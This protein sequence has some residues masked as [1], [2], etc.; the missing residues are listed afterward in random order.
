MKWHR[1]YEKCATCGLTETPHKARGVCQRCYTREYR[2]RD[3]QK[4]RDY[5]RRYYATNPEGWKKL[6]ARV[7][8]WRENNPEKVKAQL[9]RSRER[10]KEQ[11]ISRTGK[12]PKAAWVQIVPL[13]ITGQIVRQPY[14]MR[15]WV[16]DIEGKT[17]IHEAVPTKV[18]RR[19]G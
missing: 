6:Q 9:H 18:L 2:T 1:L 3:P 7:K 10:L 5:Y 4:W 16:V 15:E 17:G 11:G 14:K 13:G 8:R 19:V 12:W